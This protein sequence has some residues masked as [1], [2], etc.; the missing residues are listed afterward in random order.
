MKVCKF[1][2]SSLANAEQV[3]KVCDIVAADPDRRIVVVSAPGRPAGQ[4]DA[5]KVTDRLILCAERAL[6]GFDARGATYLRLVY[7]AGGYAV[8]EVEL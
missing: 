8:F 7:E 4:P 6:G 5:I 1:G 3:R 2:G